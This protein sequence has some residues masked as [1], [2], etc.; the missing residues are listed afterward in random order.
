[1]GDGR[2]ICSGSGGRARLRGQSEGEK[3]EGT[4]LSK[5]RLKAGMKGANA[6]S[7]DIRFHNG[8]ATKEKKDFLRRKDVIVLLTLVAKHPIFSLLSMR[9][10]CRASANVSPVPCFSCCKCPCFYTH[11][12]SDSVLIT[13]VCTPDSRAHHLLTTIKAEPC[14][15]R[16]QDVTPS[17]SSAERSVE[18]SAVPS[19]QAIRPAPRPSTQTTSN[20]SEFTA[21]TTQPPLHGT[22]CT[23]M[24]CQQS[25]PSVPPPPHSCFLS[26]PNLHRASAHYGAAPSVG[27]SAVPNLTTFP[28]LVSSVLPP[29]P[30]QQREIRTQNLLPALV[31]PGHLSTNPTVYG[32]T[33]AQAYL[34]HSSYT[35]PPFSN[36]SPQV[37]S[38][39]LYTHLTTQTPISSTVLVHTDAVLPGQSTVLNSIVGEKGIPHQLPPPKPGLRPSCPTR[40]MHMFSNIPADV[41]IISRPNTT[42]SLVGILSGT[43]P[44]FLSVTASNPVSASAASLISASN[45]VNTTTVVSSV[46]TGPN[47]QFR[48]ATSSPV[49]STTSCPVGPAAVAMVANRA[50]LPV[51]NSE[52]NALSTKDSSTR[53]VE[54]APVFELAVSS[55]LPPPVQTTTAES[56]KCSTANGANSST[57]FENVGW[58]R[59]S[60]LPNGDLQ[61]P[62]TGNLVFSNS[63]SVLNWIRSAAVPEDSLSLQLPSNAVDFTVNDIGQT[64][65]WLSRTC[66]NWGSRKN[67]HV[68]LCCHKSFTTR[69]LYESHMARPVARIYYRC[70]LCRGSDM[71]CIIPSSAGCSNGATPS[72]SV[73]VTAAD[74]M[75]TETSEP[76]IRT[77]VVS[78][79]ESDSVQKHH[80]AA[81]V[82]SPYCTTFYGG[83][84]MAPNICAVYSHLTYV[85]P[86]QFDEWAIK[87]PLLTVCPLP[88]SAWTTGPFQSSEPPN[89]HSSLPSDAG[90]NKRVLPMPLTSF[91]LSID[92]DMATNISLKKMEGGSFY[93]PGSEL[94]ELWRELE[95]TLADT[96]PQQELSFLNV[97]PSPI[98]VARSVRLTDIC[99]PRFGALD[100]HHVAM[101]SSSPLNRFNPPTYSPSGIVPLLPAP[102]FPLCQAILHL[103]CT[104][105]WYTH[106]FLNDWFQQDSP[107]QPIPL[108]L[109]DPE[110]IVVDEQDVP[111]DESPVVTDNLNPC[112]FLPPPALSHRELLEALDSLQHLREDRPLFPCA[113][114][115]GQTDPLRGTLMDPSVL[116][117]DIGKQASRNEQTKS[118]TSVLVSSSSFLPGS[119]QDRPESVDQGGLLRCLMC[120]FRTNDCKK[121]ALHLSG[122][123]PFKCTKCAFCAQSIRFSQP[124]LC[125][126]K[127]HLALHLGC[128]LMCPQCGFTPPLYL[129]PDAAELCL[130]I[131]LRFVC[132]H[133]NIIQVFL[134]IKC[135]KRGKAFNNV[136]HLTHHHFEAHCPVVYT[137]LWCTRQLQDTTTHN[138]ATNESTTIIGLCSDTSESNGQSRLTDLS[139]NNE[140]SAADLSASSTSGIHNCTSMNHEIRSLAAHQFPN[141]KELMAHFRINHRHVFKVPTPRASGCGANEKGVNSTSNSNKVV[142]DSPSNGDNHNEDGTIDEDHLATASPGPGDKSTAEKTYSVPVAFTSLTKSFSEPIT[143]DLDKSSSAPVHLVPQVDFSC[144]RLCPNCSEVFEKKET[145]TQHFRSVHVG[146]QNGV[147][148]YR[149][150]G[151]CKRLSYDIEDFRKHLS[152]CTSARRMY[153]TTFGSW[154]VGTEL[155]STA[156]PPVK[157]DEVGRDGSKYSDVSN[158]TDAHKIKPDRVLRKTLVRHPLCFCFYCGVGARRIS[159]ADALLSSQNLE[160]TEEDTVGGELTIDENVVENSP[161]SSTAVVVSGKV[162]IPSSSSKEPMYDAC[163]FSDLASLHLHENSSHFVENKSQVACPWCGHRFSCQKRK[164]IPSTMSHLR[165]H[166]KGYR[167]VSW[168]M[169]RSRVWMENAKDLPHCFCGAALLDSPLAIMSHASSHLMTLGSVGISSEKTSGGADGGLS[170]RAVHDSSGPWKSAVPLDATIDRPP[171]STTERIP[172]P[173]STTHIPCP[174]IV[175][176]HLRFGIHPELDNYLSH[177]SLSSHPFVCPVCSIQLTTRWALSE[178][179]FV[180]HWGWLCYICCAYPS[181]SNDVGCSKSSS[182][183]SV[184]ANVLENSST[185]PTSFPSTQSAPS[186]WEHVYQCISERSRLINEAC[187]T[188]EMQWIHDS[189]VIEANSLQVDDPLPHHPKSCEDSDIKSDLSTIF[190]GVLSAN[191]PKVGRRSPILIESSPDSLSYG[192]VHSSPPSVAPAIRPANTPASGH[193]LKVVSS[194]KRPRTFSDD[195]D[196]GGRESGEMYSDDKNEVK[197]GGDSEQS[198]GSN[199]T[200]SDDHSQQQEQS[201]SDQDNANASA[202]RAV[203]DT[204]VSS[205]STEPNGVASTEDSAS[206]VLNCVLCGEPQ[207]PDTWEEHSLTHRNPQMSWS[208]IQLSEPNRIVISHHQPKMYRCYVCERRFISR[209]S[210]QRHM[211]G[212]HRIR[213][214]DL[215]WDQLMQPCDGQRAFKPTERS[216]VPLKK[217]S[218][219]ADDLVGNH[220]SVQ[221]PKIVVPTESNSVSTH[222][223]STSANGSDSTR[224]DQPDVAI[225]LEYRTSAMPTSQRKDVGNRSHFCPLCQVSFMSAKSLSIHWLAAHSQSKY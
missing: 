56:T 221:S 53:M 174:Q 2:W 112:Q 224:S 77:V 137:C 183:S 23:P 72:A 118:S 157:P 36:P 138:V 85:H 136:Q 25:S 4:A 215:D 196:R 205:P 100:C 34:A 123:Q 170:I 162:R 79:R 18:A 48:P 10:G 211:V 116:V 29:R 60:H 8:A 11:S 194:R 161:V 129:P 207:T 22:Q 54:R 167:Y 208:G 180:E 1:M 93:Q 182:M 24:P 209:N 223:I 132:F 69:S 50:E 84:V 28:I 65:N 14:E 55:S 71:A 159:S 113:T 114:R 150:F 109:A 63:K 188:A 166:L 89:A 46:V 33:N 26:I 147:C 97:R 144:G 225:A 222:C 131:H 177:A 9:L 172:T 31:N 154:R 39:G 130:R 219:P 15:N 126:V 117:T 58:G 99:S 146:A 59:A 102:D 106:M 41:S 67:F 115:V 133:F 95:L 103:A 163:Y 125:A 186:I 214:K 27:A 148:C 62:D 74:N 178:H 88:D 101:T 90:D 218:S 153:E 184:N 66:S 122:T 139:K 185:P 76:P 169:E 135:G 152:V 216:V 32:F 83:V 92:P 120:H 38:V 204:D 197:D 121:L 155:D 81:S 189:P 75:D 21:R 68:C 57:Q 17:I 3:R 127:A 80:H 86:N 192:S 94:S 199:L 98:D 212:M 151:T 49:P 145:F 70:H 143:S 220:A 198:Q 105:V 175:Y 40:P 6:T 171:P 96:L 119:V 107:G 193:R 61:F 187:R 108:P 203:L 160:S 191:G 30:V 64:N 124:N 165:V 12:M 141:T 43:T 176:R 7:G 134:C 42:H 156:T 104:D 128:F 47:A 201:H 142:E 44:N 190:A 140:T 111:A 35:R 217:S 19:E 20:S 82:R 179:V 45:T 52:S 164:N 158:S 149:C 91:E 73:A 37:Q 213:R 195:G 181:S 51:S 13:K 16:Y 202:K 210:C 5:R 200:R 168:L 110:P 78:S 206:P 173:S 87:P